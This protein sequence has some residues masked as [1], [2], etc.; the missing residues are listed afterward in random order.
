MDDTSHIN[1]V[2]SLDQDVAIGDFVIPGF[3]AIA[4]SIGVFKVSTLSHQR[5]L[6]NER[7]FLTLYYSLWRLRTSNIYVSP[8]VLWKLC[9]LSLVFVSAANLSV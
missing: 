7:F 3:I 6:D 8:A 2:L 9:R 4:Y 5:L 1:Q